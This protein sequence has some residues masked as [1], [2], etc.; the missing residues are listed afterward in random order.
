M[1]FMRL[2]PTTAT[3]PRF[4]GVVV[5]TIA[6]LY[7]TMPQHRQ[8]QILLAACRRFALVKIPNNGPGWGYT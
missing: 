5:I 2:F 8:V 4:T 7:S 6:Q 3:Y 1:G